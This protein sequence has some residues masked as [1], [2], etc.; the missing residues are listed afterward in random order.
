M[1]FVA[2]CSQD[3]TSDLLL[4]RLAPAGVFRFD[5]DRFRDYVWDFSPAGFRVVAPDGAEISDRTL[6][7]FYL[8]KPMFLD[9]IDVPRGG[10]PENWCR[11][12][13]RDVFEG[14]YRECAAQGLCAL[15]RPARGGPWRKLRQMRLAARF[16]PVPEWHLCCGAPSEAA[17]GGGWVFKTLTQTPIGPGV[18]PFVRDADPAAL[19]PRYPWFLQR[20]VA[21][22]EETTVVF[23]R[24]RSFAFRLRPSAGAPV[25]S[26]IV[27]ARS[28]DDWEPVG[29][30]PNELAAVRGFMAE[31]DHDFGRFDFLRRNGRL[32]FLEMNPNGQFAWLDP[33][34]YRG[35]LDAVASEILAVA[36]SG[37][38]LDW[39]GFPSGPV[40]GPARQDPGHRSADKIEADAPAGRR[41]HPEAVRVR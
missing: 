19:S 40:D 17:P 3:R 8:R 14:L 26:R 30:A 18:Y 36:R 12:E 7:A 11:E 29:L 35:L 22:G 15:V 37:R 27:S 39:R 21:G 32:V 41:V 2:T 33:D 28:P 31:S 23:V 38:R 16:F 13:V 5:I 9:A 10:C 34:G 1:V 24:G 25:D 4:P 6:S 20:K